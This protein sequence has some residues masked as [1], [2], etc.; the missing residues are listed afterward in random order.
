M[1]YRWYM[2]KLVT[3]EHDCSVRVAH[4]K[5]SRGGEKNER[6]TRACSPLEH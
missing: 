2:H 4:K 6:G 3:W 5:R 1:G